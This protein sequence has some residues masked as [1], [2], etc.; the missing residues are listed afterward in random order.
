MTA[1]ASSLVTRP[2][3]T[4]WRQDVAAEREL[5]GLV[6]YH[7]ERFADLTVGPDHFHN[8]RRAVFR[9]LAEHAGEGC[10][11]DLMTIAPVLREAGLLLTAI[12][13]LEEWLA[14]CTPFNELE[15]RLRE[16]YVRC[17][18]DTCGT[19]LVQAARDEHADVGHLQETVVHVG[20]LLGRE[21]A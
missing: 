19:A 7:R 3:V 12:G 11:P 1:S 5:L 9:I 18:V 8:E 13:F 2:A 15:A 10:A 21:R 16:R 4:R 14:A 6:L 17:L 20:A